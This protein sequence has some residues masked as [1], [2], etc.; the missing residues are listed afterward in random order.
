[1]VQEFK[2]R[3][4]NEFVRA[5]DVHSVIELGCGDG[6]QLALADYPRYLGLD[7]SATALRRCIERFAN[8]PTKS[9]L[10]YDPEAFADRAG[11]LSA[12]LSLAIDVVYHLVEDRTYD[13]TMRQLF[14]AGRRFVIVSSSNVELEG[15]NPHVRHR[16]FTRWVE[17]NAPEWELVD[18]VMNPY[19][20]GAEAVT[21]IPK[22]FYMFGHRTEVSG[23]DT[24]EDIRLSHVSA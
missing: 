4:L 17:E 21:T 15:R 1:M 8:D 12:D 24:A 9:F 7:V 18:T 11:F 2:A 23:S 19:H 3:L 14:S 10:L 6:V 5:H 20:R 16:R 22:D 13:L